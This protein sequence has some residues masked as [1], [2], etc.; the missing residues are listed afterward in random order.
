MIKEYIE[1]LSK[2]NLESIPLNGAL[3]LLSMGYTG[4]C[5][6]KA[7]QKAELEKGGTIEKS[8]RF[9]VIIPK[10]DEK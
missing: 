1:K 9:V 6:W 7:R 3:D 10:D 4:H 2:E 8:A 5:L